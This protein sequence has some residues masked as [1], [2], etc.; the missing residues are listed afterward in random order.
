MKIV[1]EFEPKANS[2]K[3]RKRTPMSILIKK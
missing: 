2:Y 1:K 3:K